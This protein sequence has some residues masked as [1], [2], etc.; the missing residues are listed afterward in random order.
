M[1]F[2]DKPSRWMLQALLLLGLV[3]GSMQTARA[4]VNC[5]P[6]GT[7]PHNTT[8]PLSG[9]F[10]AGND[11]PMWSIIYA[12]GVS[13]ASG[14]AITLYCD[15]P[16]NVSA[17][18]R[19]TSEPSGAP[20][21]SPQGYPVFPTNVP[22]VGVAVYAKD[23]DSYFSDTQPAS[24][25]GYWVRDSAG[26]V[27]K[28]GSNIVMQ[29]VKTGPIASGAVVNASSFPS[30]T[31]NA[32]AQAG[33]SGFPMNNL[34]IANFSGSIQF[35][36]QTCTTPDVNVD[37]GQHL[38]D[39]FT[40]IGATTAWQYAPI[41]M[42]NCPTFTGLYGK[43]S[44]GEGSASYR[45]EAQ[46]SVAPSGGT[47]T[48]NLFEITLTPTT[49]L[50]DPGDPATFLFENTTPAAAT[51]M[52]YQLGYNTDINATTIG[53]G[54]VWHKGQA[55]ISISAPSDGR[56]TVKIPLFL[57]YVRYGSR[58]TPGPMNGKVVATIN[59]K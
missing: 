16:Y 25:P 41:V 8:V 21:M 2:S 39:E 46:G 15:A 14:D 7:Y 54:M 1:K 34:W 28:Y 53:S 4:D 47:L 12:V 49:E 50:A 32:P 57:R 42:S 24:M 22:G 56:A 51:G 30:V 20:V 26:N 9:V 29:L 11:L 37:L 13:N 5:A 59:Y 38:P 31:L 48:S 19:A 3:C 10:Y 43:G 44:I 58:I 27:E 40:S 17:Q 36:T 45:Q 23:A 33:Y 6:V 35:V 55:P 52:G 18:Y